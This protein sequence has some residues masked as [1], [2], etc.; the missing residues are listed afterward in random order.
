MRALLPVEEV[1]VIIPVKPMRCLRCQQPL[2]GEDPQPQRH[3]VTEI[4]TGQTGGHRVWASR[5]SGT[6]NVDPSSK[7][8]CGR[9]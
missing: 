4:P 8:C 1:D 2:Q 5:S 3:Q 9:H 6:K 7:V